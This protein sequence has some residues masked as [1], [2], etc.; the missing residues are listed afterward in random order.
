M[1]GNKGF[2]PS[3]QPPSICPCNS[4]RASSPL[5]SAGCPGPPEHTH[6]TPTMQTGAQRPTGEQGYTQGHAGAHAGQWRRPPWLPKGRSRGPE[7]THLRVLKE[8]VLVIDAAPAAVL[9]GVLMPRPGATQPGL[10][11]RLVDAQVRRIDHTALDNVG[12]VSAH[13]LEGHPG[14][15]RGRGWAGPPG[16]PP[17][18]SPCVL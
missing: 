14:C 1:C 18:Y 17:A 10:L 9:P 11:P 4:G 15:G 6:P 13:V 16:W 8:G 7:N 12:E 5:P 2:E 3:A